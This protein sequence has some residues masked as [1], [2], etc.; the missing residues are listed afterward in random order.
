MSLSPSFDRVDLAQRQ[1]LLGRRWGRGG[2][3]E[4]GTLVEDRHASITPVRDALHWLWRN[5]WSRRRGMTGPR[6]QQISKPHSASF[7]QDR[8][9]C[10]SAACGNDAD[11]RFPGNGTRLH[12]LTGCGAA[13]RSCADRAFM[14]NSRA[15]VPTPTSGWLSIGSS[16]QRFSPILRSKSRTFTT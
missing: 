7:A 13:S 1:H 16:W 10:L 5:A 9:N 4:P 6:F 12:G 11:G 14:S 15:L 3:L 8:V 2:H